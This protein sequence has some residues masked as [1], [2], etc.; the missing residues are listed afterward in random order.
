MTARQPLLDQSVG[1]VGAL[2]MSSPYGT[3]RQPRPLP[4]QLLRPWESST[5]GTTQKLVL[6]TTAQ[7]PHHAP[8]GQLFATSIAGNDLTSSILFTAG[9]C[10]QS[11]GIWAPVSLLVVTFTLYLY[12]GIYTEVASALP[13]NGG[14]YN[15]L[16]NTTNKLAAGVVAAM[17]V[18]AYLATALVDA[19]AAVEYLADFPLSALQPESGIF[20]SCLLVLA[21]VTVL[22]LIGLTESA[23]VATA[24]FFFNCLTYAILLVFSVSHCIKTGGAT[25]I[26]NLHQ[27]PTAAL[28]NPYGSIAKNI[29][30]GYCAALLGVTGFE[31]SCNYI[32]EQKPGVFPKTLRNMWWL[33]VLFNP[34]I[35]FMCLAV[36]PMDQIQANTDHLLS[37]MGYICAG[38]WLR[39]WVVVD[40]FLILTGTVLTAFV[41]VTGLL[42]RM[43]T[44]RV[45]PT[46]FMKQ[47][48]L[49]GTRHYIIVGFFLLTASLWMMSQDMDVLSGVFDIAFLTVLS[50]MAVANMLIKYKRDA[51]RRE[52]EEPWA[53]VLLGFV[54]IFG[55]LVGTI[56][57]KPVVVVY[58]IIYF[59]AVLALILGMFCRV[60]LLNV[61]LYFVSRNAFLKKR[62]AA[63]I[64]AS[65]GDIRQHPL[66]FFSKT[67]SIAILNK[68]VLYCRE[69]EDS[70]CLTVVHVS[71]RDDTHFNAQLEHAVQQ[72]DDIYPKIRIN[73]LFVEGT[74]GPH[75]IEPLSKYLNTAPNFM[76]V[77]CPSRS[78]PYDLAPFGGV[79]LITRNVDNWGQDSGGDLQ[80]S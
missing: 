43:S 72:L 57:M 51:L 48:K 44:D 62:F 21:F 46:F 13:F 32:E 78:F 10:I 12:R 75:I 25:L 70:D 45:L 20:W 11:A 2:S 1:D 34:T 53:T 8:L 63:S 71:E 64:Q 77:A 41:G 54:M 38:D 56:A 15:A 5:Y 52:K 27:W 59:G 19:A 14:S 33:V 37:H 58:F 6:P 67:S 79:R 9:L 74:F 4:P 36:V 22:N 65:I 50:M 23:I 60:K 17:A 80:F 24:F 3:G 69:N 28:A 55:G 42:T 16:L 7:K 29:F 49:R 73:L 47:N 76:F 68:V 31:T 18:L 26:D 40:A 39:R 35:A 66:V 61:V 30:Y